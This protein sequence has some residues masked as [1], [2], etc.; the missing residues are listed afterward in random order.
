MIT[1]ATEPMTDSEINAAATRTCIEA[2]ALGDGD[3]DCAFAILTGALM[4]FSRQMG[5]T[6]KRCV[7]T[8]REMFKANQP[9]EEI[10]WGGSRG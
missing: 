8:L 4:H 7:A 1:V 9:R 2:I 6:D 5:M 3:P 10:L